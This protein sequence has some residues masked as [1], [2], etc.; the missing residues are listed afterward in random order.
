MWK[1][2][3][4]AAYGKAA[5]NQRSH[6][7]VR[8]MD[9]EAALK[10]HNSPLHKHTVVVSPDRCYEVKKKKETIKLSLPFTVAL[11]VYQWAKVRVSYYNFYKKCLKSKKFI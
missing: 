3:G 11:F 2:L 4:N 5:T 8:Y 1:L 6:T 10:E 7:D 9:K